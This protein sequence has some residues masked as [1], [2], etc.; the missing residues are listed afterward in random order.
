MFFSHQYFPLLAVTVINFVVVFLLY[1]DL[2]AVK[3]SISQLSA[4]TKFDFGMPDDMEVL[5]IIPA[6]PIEVP[7]PPVVEE[8]KEITK[9][10]SKD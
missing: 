4:P 5:D 3:A 8:K 9:K 7:E 10:K 2:N 6:S 1:R